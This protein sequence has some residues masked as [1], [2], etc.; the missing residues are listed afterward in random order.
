MSVIL[1]S[2]NVNTYLSTRNLS[3]ESHQFN[4]EAKEAK[5][6]N[7][8]ITFPN[9]NQLLVKQERYHNN[10]RTNGTFSQ[11]WAIYQWVKDIIPDNQIINLFTEVLDFDLENSIMVVKYLGHYSDL[12]H[13]YQTQKIYSPDIASR[14]GSAIASIHRITFDSDKTKTFFNQNKI[15]FDVS[16]IFLYGLEEISPV[17]FSKVSRDNLK[18]Y[19]LYQR[20]LNLQKE[21]QTMKKN[22]HC[23][24][25]IHNDLNFN[26]ILIHNHWEDIKSKDKEED[27]I[28]KI[29]DWELFTWGD[30]RL[31]LGNLIANYLNVWLSSFIITSDIDIQTALSLA[32][33]P[34]EKVQPSIVA[35]I[36]AYINSFPEI[37]Q[38]YPDFFNKTMQFAG[39]GL[40]EKI[41]ADVYYHQPFDNH[42]ICML[43]VANTLVCHP[44]KSL[45]I[46]SGKSA[47]ELY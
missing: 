3:N 25:L 31:D 46:V 39:V 26:N 19:K 21:I 43:Q 4:I 13:F 27:S 37:I 40:M 28:I 5:N 32:M 1:S 33:I 15:N 45:Q 17:I 24:C 20:A 35:L 22:Y 10:G 2:E 38:I 11:E 44:E 42:S 9:E 7:L 18:F 12:K 47:S 8:L 30:P 16:P 23:R 29:I 34:L 36:K 41:L 14:L 6:F